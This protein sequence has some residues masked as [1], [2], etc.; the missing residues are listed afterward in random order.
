[1]NCAVA[2]PVHVKDLVDGLNA[3]N[4]KYLKQMMMRITLTGNEE[5][6]REE[7]K[8]YLKG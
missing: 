2:D 4:N 6:L 5:A 1:M 3:C 7:K 8:S